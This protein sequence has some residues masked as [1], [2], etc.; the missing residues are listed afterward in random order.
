[1][2]LI[3]W[4]IIGLL[5][6][7]LMYPYALL[8]LN[9]FIVANSQIGTSKFRFSATFR[10]YGLIFLVAFG[11]LLAGGALVAVLINIADFFALF[12]AFIYFLFFLY[13]QV[14]LQNLFFNS[15]LL[16]KNQFKAELRLGSYAKV[17]LI[18]AALMIL[19]VG[20]Y[21]PAAKV[22][23][24]RYIADNIFFIS[25]GPIEVLVAEEEQS[26]SA[27]GEELGEG[28]DVDIGGI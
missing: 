1:M 21:F 11:I 3:F 23:L 7:G 13:L 17:L 6:L 19:T 4:P 16:G 8:K 2:A 20:L 10:D 15:S 22:R 28:F 24:A 18:N 25:N 12:L 9:R 27:L 26:V 14:A 5:T